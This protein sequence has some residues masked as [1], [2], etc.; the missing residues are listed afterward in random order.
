MKIDNAHYKLWIKQLAINVRHIL[1]TF[2]ESISIE[3]L[4]EKVHQRSNKLIYFNI[5]PYP[6]KMRVKYFKKSV[7]NVKKQERL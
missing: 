1:E 4:K 7:F 5:F 6:N 2:L 3:N